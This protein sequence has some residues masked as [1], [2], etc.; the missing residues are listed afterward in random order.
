MK[1]I[2]YLL[3]STILL[4]GCSTSPSTSPSTPT[5]IFGVYQTDDFNESRIYLY[6][7]STYIQLE[8]TFEVTETEFDGTKAGW[9]Y[10]YSDDKIGHFGNYKV[11]DRES[12]YELRL[13]Y[14]DYGFGM[15]KYKLQKNFTSFYLT[16]NGGGK[17]TGTRISGEGGLIKR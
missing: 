16:Q 9:K 5:S 7:D 12:F 8:P 11:I 1:K 3:I 13:Y 14:E 10:I 2:I 4:Y 15:G 17:V 6:S